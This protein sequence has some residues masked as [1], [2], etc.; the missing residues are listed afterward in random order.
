[1]MGVLRMV[2]MARMARAVGVARMPGRTGQGWC[3]WWCCR[4]GEGGEDGEDAED[5]GNGGD[6]TDVEDGRVGASSLVLGDMAA[7]VRIRCGAAAHDCSL[8]AQL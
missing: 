6:C 8:D 2:G 7:N 5:G 1:M 4:D 3:A